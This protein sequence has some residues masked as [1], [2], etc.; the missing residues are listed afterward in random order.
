MKRAAQ[1]LSICCRAE[2][3]STALKVSLLVGLVL[4][5]VNQGGDLLAGHAIEWGHTL[6]NFAVP[7]CVSSYS[8]ALNVFRSQRGNGS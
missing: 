3:A 7:Y 1:L 2:V 6:L 5:L 4:N 8:T